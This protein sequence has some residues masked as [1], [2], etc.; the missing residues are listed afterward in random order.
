MTSVME[1][2]RERWSTPEYRKKRACQYAIQFCVRK[3]W[4]V[5]PD[6]C[7]RCDSEGLIEGHHPDY[8]KPLEVVWLCKRCH[9]AEHPW[10][11]LSNK[12]D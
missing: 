4:L 7:S 12:A 8:S 11:E 6:A 10:T 9:K 1:K 5:R 2:R 3:G